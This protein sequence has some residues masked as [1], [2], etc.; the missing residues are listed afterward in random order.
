MIFLYVIVIIINLSFIF[1]IT[2]HKQKANANINLQDA[3]S[4]AS[5]QAGCNVAEQIQDAMCWITEPELGEECETGFY[6]LE[7]S[8]EAT[9]SGLACSSDSDCKD[10]K[11]DVFGNPT[12]TC[13][14]KACRHKYTSSD[15]D[16]LKSKCNSPYG[17][18][19]EAKNK[20]CICATKPCAA[21][22]NSVAKECVLATQFQK[23]CEETG[24]P[25][26][27]QPMPTNWTASYKGF[28]GLTSD[29]WKNT[30]I[31]SEWKKNSAS[32]NINCDDPYNPQKNCC[33]Y[34]SY[35]SPFATCNN[36]MRQMKNDQIVQ[37]KSWWNTTG[38]FDKCQSQCAD[39]GGAIRC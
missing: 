29:D 17:M 7:Q 22:W 24:W 31:C 5:C 25:S 4:E 16:S 14:N 33:R 34:A 12:N 1:W 38:A 11:P 32:C 10:S 19:Y 20:Q 37:P 36:F 9:C 8:C 18:Y 2:F 30:P 23:H 6:Y 15:C 28:S 3:K 27:K 35:S 13:I 21:V 26:T 39:V